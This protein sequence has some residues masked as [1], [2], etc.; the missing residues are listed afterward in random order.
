MR[1]PTSK[2]W[3]IPSAAV[4][5]AAAAF[6]SGL[7]G[8]GLGGSSGG[9]TVVG[10]SGSPT[11]II[12]RDAVSGGHNVTVNPN[13]NSISTNVNTSVIAGGGATGA[14]NQIGTLGG[15]H[16]SVAT[17]GGGYDNLNNQQA[18]TIC[19][20]AHHTLAY[21]ASSSGHGTVGGGSTNTISATGSY[22]TIGGGSTNSE[23]GGA[24]RATIAGG[25]T[26]SCTANGCSIGG[27]FT[28][29]IAD[30][31]GTVSGGNTNSCASGSGYCTIS[32]GSNN[33]VS[34]SGSHSSILAGST[35]SID[36]TGGT[37]NYATVAGGFTNKAQ[38]AGATCIGG[39]TNTASGL[40]SAI[41][42]GQ[43]NVASGAESLV[44][45][46]SGNT[47]AGANS[48]VLGGIGSVANGDYSTATG[49]YA[50]TSTNMDGW[51]CHASGRFTAA[52]DAQ[53][54][55]TTGRIQTTSAT[56]GTIVSAGTQWEILDN[57][58]WS[59]T[60][61]VVGRTA[62]GQSAGYLFQGLIE[63]GSG[64]ATTAFVGGTPTATVLG[65]DNAAWDAIAVA[66]TSTGTL[67][68]N[69]TG[70]AATTVNWVATLE[71]TSVTL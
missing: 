33:A 28:N 19:G 69:V 70:A 12:Q 42:G 13:Y 66:S 50:V 62:A 21:N 2:R 8:G 32:G 67:R 9:G 61:R 22:N 71:V 44:L 11:D 38:N 53:T 64:V 30:Q 43:T 36:A 45:G 6:A 68:I 3:L 59:F 4:L 37:P 54:C 57:T 14:A 16:A 27:G 58:S 60:V 51:H 34:G 35:N 5:V 48:S 10:G 20:G 17:I 46:G 39:L 31:F 40:R 47:A 41:L 18:G 63:R 49:F 65:E 23:T 52:G 24:D 29:S 1:K 56:A 55:V 7:G 15:T 26:N 25:S